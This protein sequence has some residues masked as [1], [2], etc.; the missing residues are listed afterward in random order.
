MA[1]AP[2][3]PPHP[4][5]R[6]RRIEVR[7]DEGRRR[8][9]RLI[10][11]VV[12]LALACAAAALTRSPA[13]DVDRISVIGADHTTAASIAAVAGLRHRQPMMDVDG[14]AAARQIR[15]LPWVEDA[16][17]QRMWPG[18]V[19]I[20]ITE[21]QAVAQ[22]RAAAGWAAVDGSG[23][24]L[25]VAKAAFPSLVRI[26]RV[27]AAAPGSSIGRVAR[28]ALELALA[29]PPELAAQAASVS[30]RA[31]G[32]LTVTLIEDDIAVNFGPAT[33]LPAK[34]QALA[35]L[36]ASAVRTPPIKTIDVSVPSASV[37][38]RERGR[39]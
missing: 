35:A 18:T 32:E 25:Q 29:L 31:G 9:Q 21:R 16:S 17:V 37:L 8:R 19:Q 7:R 13:L 10:V 23:R 33:E 28:P 34:A 39:A 6:A 15:T 38:T 22:V 20:R 27:V 26:N 3:E 24:V 30:I 1:A 12:V 14:G 2:V 4:R 5:I 11:L 36:L